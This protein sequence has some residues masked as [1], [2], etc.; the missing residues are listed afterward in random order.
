MSVT[1]LKPTEIK[2]INNMKIPIHYSKLHHSFDWLSTP[3]KSMKIRIVKQ[4][5]TYLL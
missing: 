2:I 5:E 4:R 1:L 3:V